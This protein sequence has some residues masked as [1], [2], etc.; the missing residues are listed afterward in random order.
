V[1]APYNADM[2]GRRLEDQEGLNCPRTAAQVDRHGRRRWAS[3]RRMFPTPPLPEYSRIKVVRSFAELV[4]TPLA[5]GVN[6]LCWP[7][8]LPGDFGEVIA[9]LGAGEGIVPLDETRLNALAL[10]EAGRLAR[11]LMLADLRLLRDQGLAPE[12]NCIHAYPRDVDAAVVPVDVYSFHADSAPVETSTW[13][14]PTMG[15]LPRACAT[16]RRN[17]APMCPPPALPCSR[18]TAERMT[19]ASANS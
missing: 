8:I 16:K 7:R 15:R 5:D 18:N 3:A 1:P 11:E 10:S 4:A 19:P 12:L 14:A 13:L 17:G 9:R 2:M 6:A